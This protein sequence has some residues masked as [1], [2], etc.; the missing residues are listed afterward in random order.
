MAIN[1]EIVSDKENKKPIDKIIAV[2]N[3]AN[4]KNKEFRFEINSN[5]SKDLMKLNLQQQ[6]NNDN[7]NESEACKIDDSSTTTT[8]TTTTTTSSTTATPATPVTVPQTLI[9]CLDELQHNGKLVSWK[10]RGEG[11]NLTVKVTW[12]SKNNEKKYRKYTTTLNRKDKIYQGNYFMSK[13][14]YFSWI[15]FFASSFIYRK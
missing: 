7:L 5:T 14:L 9:S 8:T 10:I 3:D 15:F 1:D 12:N 11:E 13:K 4:N 2:E 6:Q